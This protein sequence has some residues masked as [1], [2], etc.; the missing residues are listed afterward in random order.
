MR[1]RGIEIA[2]RALIAVIAALAAAIAVL[3]FL[4]GSETHY[5]DGDEVRSAGGLFVAAA[6]LGT[7]APGAVV[8]GRPRPWLLWA[9]CAI[10]IVTSGVGF[11]FMDDVHPR[12]ADALRF[13]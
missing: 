8:W 3:A 13:A 1:S 6:A 9:W 12:Y 10:A 11:A 5:P 4:P 7:A 2:V